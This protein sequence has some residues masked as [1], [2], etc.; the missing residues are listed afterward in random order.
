[1][2]LPEVQAI[3]SD[4]CKQFVAT[5]ISLVGM[6]PVYVALMKEPVTSTAP[7]DQTL[8]P[9]TPIVHIAPMDLP[10]SVVVDA[11][12]QT[13]GRDVLRLNTTGAVLHLAPAVE[14]LGF[15]HAQGESVIARV[16]LIRGVPMFGA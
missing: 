6:N 9:R 16:H 11:V 3:G 15:I 1:M 13:I 2:S 7:V 10:V 8:G 12:A 14:T 4:V 5:D